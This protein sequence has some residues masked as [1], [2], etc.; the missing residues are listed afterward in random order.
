MQVS[1][2]DS[3]SV[4]KVLISEPD[5]EKDF[6][7]FLGQVSDYAI[8]KKGLADSLRVVRKEYFKCAETWDTFLTIQSGNE[9]WLAARAVGLLNTQEATKVLLEACFEMK[10][11]QAERVPRDDATPH[12]V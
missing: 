11:E 8:F 5:K 1:E 3:I 9:F 4:F 6:I 10:R 2:T 7:E 12:Y